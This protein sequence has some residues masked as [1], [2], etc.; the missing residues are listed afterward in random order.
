VGGQPIAASIDRPPADLTVARAR[1]GDLGAFEELYRRHV[2]GV[3][4]LCLRMTADPA[5]AED[6]TQET[7]VRAWQKLASYRGEARFPAWLSRVAINVVRGE[8][9]TRG[10]RE[11]RERPLDESAASPPAPP[12][13][14]ALDLERAIAGLPA[15]AREVFVLHDVEGYRHEEVAGLLDVKPGTSKSQLHRARKLLREALSR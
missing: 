15:G 5:R 3:Y 13:G 1:S 11:E 2:N 12:R 14:A 10:R 8:W 7:F 4:A 6:H 9:R